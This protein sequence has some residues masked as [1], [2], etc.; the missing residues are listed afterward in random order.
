[1]KCILLSLAGL[2]TALAWA[3]PNAA[4]QRA[5]IAGGEETFGS[6]PFAK[7]KVLA[8]DID[9]ASPTITTYAAATTPLECFQVAE[10]V[11]SPAGL[12][13]LPDGSATR[14]LTEN[15]NNAA[16][17]NEAPCG[18]VLMEHTFANSYGAPFI[19]KSGS[20]LL[21]SLEHEL[22]YRANPPRQLHSS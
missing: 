9:A 7:Y 8:L 14:A 18:V 22:L 2:A 1:M 15:G 19:G 12:S 5:L 21:F 3:R 17:G 10:P 16:T 13:A 11:P 4:E 6:H 20:Y